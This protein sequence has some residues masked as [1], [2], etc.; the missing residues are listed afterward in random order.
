MSSPTQEAESLLAVNAIFADDF[1]EVLV[2][3]NAADTMLE[4]AEKVAEH[5]ENLRVRPTGLPKVVYFE[6]REM[7]DTCTVAEAGIEQMDHI[8][9]DYRDDATELGKSR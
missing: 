5:A 8:R 9:V 2:F 4:V 6:E 7:L 1:T 3:I